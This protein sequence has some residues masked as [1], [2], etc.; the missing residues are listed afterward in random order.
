MTAFTDSTPSATNGRSTRRLARALRLGRSTA[1]DG[2]APRRDE[3]PLR[4]DLYSVDQLAGHARTLAGWHEAQERPGREERLL[5]RLEEN[6]HVL[7]EAY[8]A[9]VRAAEKGRRITPAAEWLVDNFYLIEEQVRLARRHLPRGYARELPRLLNGP[10]AGRPR[11]YD[12]A[13]EL[14]S[15]VDAQVDEVALTRF[16]RSY[17]S[18]MPLKLGELWAV[19]IMLR[20]ALIENLRRVASRVA[21]GQR[22]QDQ[23]AAWAGR[24]TEA[25]RNDP[26]SVVRVL[27]DLYSALG[28]GDGR[29]ETGDGQ[30]AAPAVSRLPSPVSPAEPVTLSP[31][32][33]A[34]FARRLQGQGAA[35]SFPLEW[36]G[37]ALGEQGRTVEA[38]VQAES[39]RQAAD[40]VSIGN[41]VGSLRFVE[42]HDWPEWVESCSA[43]EQALR[44][45]P[46][47]V[48][49]DCDFATRDAYRHAVETIAKECPHTEQQVAE[50]AVER[51]RKA[52]NGEGGQGHVGHHLVGRGR[53]EFERVAGVRRG[54]VGQI[55]R[56]VRLAPLAWFL[57][58]VAVV[59]VA[60]TV[61]VLW[62]SIDEGMSAWLVAVLAVP[63]LIAASQ[64]AVSL[65]NWCI[66]A[67]ATPRPLA[68]LDFDDGIPAT[69]KAVVV[70]P[71]MLTDA[72]R[73]D[74]LVQGLEIRHL[75]NPDDN[76]LFALLSDWPDADEAQTAGDAALVRHAADAVRDLNDR[77][78]FGE[79][80]KFMLFH[81]PRRWN[82]GEGVWMGWERKRGKL[83]EFNR[84]LRPCSPDADAAVKAFDTIVARRDA[85][86]GV[87]YVI[88][89]DA[90]TE[91]PRG[92]A[93]KMVA[94]MAHP[95]N[96]PVWDE[97]LG[98]VVEGYGIL[99]PRV[100]TDLPSSRASL[101]ARAM[102]GEPG[103]DPYTQASGDAYQDAF[104]EGSFVGKG[105][106]DADAFERACGRRF[107]EN[108]VLSHDLIESAY[109]R[110]G[111]LSD[112]VLYEDYPSSYLADARRRHRWV[113]GD[114]QIAGHAFSRSGPSALSRWKIVDNLR[115]SLV[116]IALLSAVVLAWLFQPGGAWAWTLL[117]LG[118]F[119]VPPLANGAY[120][121][122][123]QSFGEHER[124]WRMR[125]R[126]VWG[127]LRGDLARAAM[128]LA[129]L[130]FE[131]WNCLDAIARAAWRMLVSKRKL[132]EWQTAADAE[133]AGRQD[134]PA[135]WERMWPGYLIAVLA[136][137]WLL[138]YGAWG[139]AV[140]AV[141]PL[142]L[143]WAFSP[144]IAWA[145]SRK[146]KPR[147]P[148]ASLSAA[149]R[150][151]ARKLS[152][153][154]WSFFDRY[155]TAADGFLPPDNV[156]EVP[157]ERV[158]GRTSPTNLGLGL[159][160]Y[161]AAWDFGYVTL[162][163]L[164]DR[165]GRTLG[166]MAGLERHETGHFFNWYDTRALRPLEPRYV[167]AV[168]SGNLVASLHALHAGLTELPDR[169][170]FGP[171]TWGGLADVM[172]LLLDT[173]NGR[174]KVSL[175]GDDDA[176][177]PRKRPLKLPADLRS[178]IEALVQDCDAGGPGKLGG[179]K[180]LLQKTSIAAAEA[181][182]FCAAGGG[183]GGG[184]NDEARRWAG[185]FERQTARAAEEL[186]HL[187][188]WVDLVG[189]AVPHPANAGAESKLRLQ[190][191]DRALGELDAYP[192]L[193]QV[194][195]LAESAVPD[196]AAAE[197][198][199]EGATLRPH[200]DLPYFQRLHRILADAAKRSADRI[201]AI[202]ELAATVRSLI[203]C[204]WSV[205]YDRG[206]HLL[207]IGYNVAERRKD[208]G[209][210]DL[211]ASEMRLGSFALVAS[212]VLPAEHWFRLGRQV[213]TS[214]GGHAA[215]LSWS[216][217]MFE[218]L[219]PLLLMPTY[220]GTLLD[221]TYRGVID[222]QIEYARTNGIKPGVPWGVSESGYSA[223]D[224]ELVYQ[225]R[226]FGVPGLG[227]KRGLGED[228]V[229]APY[230]SMMAV[231]VDPTAAVA[232]L[233]RLREEGR[234]GR[235][236]FFEAIDYTPSRL[237]RGRTEAVVRQFMAHHQAMGFLAAAYV[238]LD[239][240]MQ[241]RL[242]G[243]PAF[244]SAELLLHERASR[245]APV[246][247][248]AGEHAGSRRAES[249]ATGTVRV[250]RDPATPTPEVHL[251]SNGRLHVMVT[252]AGGGYARWDAGERGGGKTLA[253]TRWREDAT[254][255]DHGTFVYLRDVETGEFWANA[256]H[257]VPR[258]PD[259]YEAIFS[260][261]RAE[262]RRV[263]SGGR[264][265]DGSRD[266]R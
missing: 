23:A 74:E 33:V 158:A 149:D 36:L 35:G 69:A 262:W 7:R 100:A 163:Q 112:V 266:E 97:S 64:W 236:G 2:E 125:A 90:D 143:V 264:R 8:G 171:Q 75:A 223:T 101:Y 109:A 104:G 161:L 37:Q 192:T 31:A 77:H 34:E 168:D 180:M 240:P 24:V 253:V 247:P 252:V 141:L 38:L 221:E 148:V 214:Q 127:S 215:L 49:P 5:G 11:V 189:P 44:G 92:A 165:C 196:A 256:H 83:A 197:R 159:L 3:Q 132:L 106:Y 124:P 40:Q 105:V 52:E 201:T 249:A 12:L 174:E 233:R 265:D 30:T 254:R 182:Q 96:R 120:A 86:F 55:K 178:K 238:L 68:K 213:T 87:D 212:G 58:G 175:P 9:A 150:R 115:R 208:A 66:T 18:A 242:M 153:R 128:G 59:S 63:V 99:Q 118:Y 121:L 166:T 67:L 73:V 50:L 70:V 157:H 217:S 219:M 260:Q 54:F 234:L 203:D 1:T 226:P 84:L 65:A 209:Y 259:R 152:R 255:D 60:A 89:L 131:A 229:I 136:V 210:Y 183:G 140:F 146:A 194:A 164:M 43:V 162:G 139:Q 94:A 46:A 154:T 200:A 205:V 144:S 80:A 71:C 216:G 243:R 224:A 81:R 102:S 235:Y 177:P 237:K 186:H 181:A 135:H 93:A 251:L 195:A 222:R 145:V 204:D 179:A 155:V 218:Y 10:N 129:F 184:D 19:P 98:R 107:P 6:H 119:F 111:L 241:R 14:V 244:K 185:E 78:G 261:A 15:H 263:D 227:Y 117:L 202:D 22:D 26:K 25:V 13:L 188:P 45:D 20:L 4:G 76:L 169:P 172:R 16:V 17:Q 167:S 257:P 122:L 103:V 198:E 258:K 191:L 225:Y 199:V 72:D 114:W 207:H 173:C 57:G 82:E 95:L 176:K 21:F 206:R 156:S 108:R 47:G 248:H 137:V 228:L 190:R 53:L 134:H 133:R 239:R 113:R 142:A 62:H 193:R 116:P 29:R 151:F 231:M 85:L 41:S 187:C 126:D 246:F 51:A 211:L 130:P 32:F 39:Q 220:D 110:S 91:L 147:P 250:F 48:Y 170:A 232:N 61:A 245:S 27:A 160:S 88:P 42:S 28:E 230:A 56:L 123:R 138:G 79:G